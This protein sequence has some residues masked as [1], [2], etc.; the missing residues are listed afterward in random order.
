MMT[1]SRRRAFIAK[2]VGTY[3]LCKLGLTKVFAASDLYIPGFLIN[4]YLKTQFPISKDWFVVKA[5]FSNPNLT[6]IPGSQRLALNTNLKISLMGSTSF[7]GKMLCSSS[8]TYDE[9]AKTLKLKSPTIDRLDFQQ[10]GDKEKAALTQINSLIS[11]L[12][13]GFTVYEFKPN[14]R[15]LL[16]TPPKQILV[17]DSGIRLI[18]N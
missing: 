2:M 10:L 9:V 6:F 14:E 13:D 1:S 18:F 11:K 3:A 5:D 8:F 16:G 15:S 17:E 12:F 4:V 7:E